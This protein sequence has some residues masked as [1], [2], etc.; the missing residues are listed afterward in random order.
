[1][2]RCAV[3]CFVSAVC[4]MLGGCPPEA[5]SEWNLPDDLKPQVQAPRAAVKGQS[6]VLTAQLNHE[7]DP[8]MV[9]YR[10][11]QVY[12]RAVE[13]DGADTPEA[14]F[15]AP[16]LP[17]DQV[18]RFRL[19]VRLPDGTVRSTLVEVLVAAD[20]DYVPAEQAGQSDQGEPE[21][22]YPR[23]RLVTSMGTITVELNRVKAPLTVNNFLRYVDDDFYDNTLFH[24]VIPDF[25]IQGG[26]YE[27]GLVLK[28]T[29]PPIISEANNGLSNERGTIAMAR[30][31][32]PDSA[33][34]QFYINLVDNTHLDYEPGGS[35]GYTVFGEVV[36]GMDVVDAIAQVETES[37]EGLDDVPVN[38]V[39]LI[40]AERVSESSDGGYTDSG[41]GGAGDG[42]IADGGKGGGGGGSF[43][44]GKDD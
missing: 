1:M 41:G 21:D 14:S 8:D 37:R 28:E 19:D 13:L 12:G 17:E 34:S 23:V 38:D 29:R 32:D 36:Q 2:S 15:V 42:S 31:R 40:R 25:I 9:S 5:P 24:R 26:G 33:T 27:A 7:I 4:L 11:Y 39:L 16:S 30:R 10:W 18:L 6:I 43:V 22:P 3:L 44:S 35:D 20:P